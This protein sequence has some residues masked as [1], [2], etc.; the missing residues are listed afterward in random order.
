MGG[1]I[2][3]LLSNRGPN[4][5]REMSINTEHF[6]IHFAGFVY[7]NILWQQGA[8]LC[9]QPFSHKHHILLING[10]I[11]SKRDNKL[12]SDTEWLA[13]MIDD[14]SDND[15]QLFEMFRSLK[16]PY[17]LI[18]LN[19]LTQKLYFLRDVLGR[20]SLLLAKSSQG[21]IILSSVLTASK[22]EHTK[23]IELPPLGI[24]CMNLITE[25]ITLNPWQ[26]I[27][28]TH[29]E[30]MNEL[31]NL[32]QAEIEIES[33]T[34]S[35]WLVKQLRE[36][37][38]ESYNFE[39]ILKD[40]VNKSSNEIFERLL[41]NSNAVSVCD[42]IEMRLENSILDRIQA[43]PSVCRQCLQSNDTHCNH[44]RIGILFS[45]GID[46]TIL[47]VIT[48]KLLDSGQPI[49]LINVSFEKVSRS[50]SAS[51]NAPIDYNT[52]DRLSARDSLRELQ[53]INPERSVQTRF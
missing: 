48:D 20:Q 44:A 8:K 2:R 10:D 4:A 36:E 9:E 30:Q 32:F 49:D 7:Y 53:R 19:Q 47:A 43:T 40:C 24:F 22:H 12:L 23:C 27:N 17:S 39:C 33:N 15:A 3:E 11:F 16:G 50:T 42:E 51:S 35:P 6:M 5:H 18:Y 1:Q 25:E 34:A 45:G 28:T 52:P 46:C 38:L 31:R 26:P 21:D 13:Q 41:S 29:V 14:C 37:S